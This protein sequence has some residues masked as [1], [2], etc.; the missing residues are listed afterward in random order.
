A[1]VIFLLPGFLLL[2]RERD[3]EANAASSSMDDEEEKD[4]KEVPT[5]ADYTATAVS[6]WTYC[7]LVFLTAV[8]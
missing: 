7:A 1:A 6:C 4:V 2:V 8:A 5:A 3:S